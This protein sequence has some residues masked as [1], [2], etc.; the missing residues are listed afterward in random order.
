MQVGLGQLLLTP[1][2]FYDMTLE[3][4]NAAVIGYAKNMD[5]LE[6]QAWER[7]RFLATVVLQPHA[8]KG[9]RIRAQDICKFPWEKI[10]TKQSAADMAAFERNAR[11]AQ[12]NS[13]ISL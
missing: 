6:M 12:E 2:A 3:E 9:K 11:W 13:V 10:A 4:F 8:K 7:T 5:A 1:S